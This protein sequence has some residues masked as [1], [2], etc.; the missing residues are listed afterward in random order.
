MM[1]PVSMLSFWYGLML[2][3]GNSFHRMHLPDCD[4]CRRQT[5]SVPIS[6]FY[7]KPV[8][9]TTERGKYKEKNI[10]V[11]PE[12]KMVAKEQVTN[13]HRI[14]TIKHKTKNRS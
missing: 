6:R 13:P 2:S 9:I 7:H 14:V 12:G 10:M 5:A 8:R 11:K 1:L 4:S 3:I